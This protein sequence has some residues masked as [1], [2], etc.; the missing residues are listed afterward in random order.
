[1]TWVALAHA[2]SWLAGV[3]IVLTSVSAASVI[4]RP[5]RRMLRL[6]AD[7][8]AVVIMSAIGIRGLIAV[9]H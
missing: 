2:N 9:S 7:S 5:Q 3:G 8:I 6:G 1:M 4:L